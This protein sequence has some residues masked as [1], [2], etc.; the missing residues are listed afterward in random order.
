MARQDR[1]GRMATKVKTENGFTRVTYHTTDVVSFDVEHIW[2]DTGGWFTSTTKTRMNQASNKFD[3]G[4]SVWQRESVWYV[5]FN[6]KEHRFTGGKLTL[7]REQ[8]LWKHS[9]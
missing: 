8:K 2:L 7:I 4:F 6:G 1:I 9:R 3:L 5:T